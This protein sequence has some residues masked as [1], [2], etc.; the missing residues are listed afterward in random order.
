MPLPIRAERVS[1]MN[2]T[3]AD[4]FWVKMYRAP[5]TLTIASGI[6]T[7]T[8]WGWYK[9][10]TEGAAATDDLDKLVGVP[11][12]E[13]VILR[14]ANAARQVVLRH[15][16]FLKLADGLDFELLTIYDSI[17]LKSWGSDVLVEC[18]GGRMRVPT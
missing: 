18:H 8:G 12:G 2:P 5:Q 15:G 4:E 16:T 11:E 1:D 9:V 10:D 3:E 17:V 6:V 14:L 13:M 7:T